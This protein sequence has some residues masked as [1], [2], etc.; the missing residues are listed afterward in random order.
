MLL[1]ILLIFLLTHSIVLCD[2]DDRDTEPIYSYQD[3]GTIVYREF[4]A[5]YS[6]RPFCPEGQQLT[7]M[8]MMSNCNA[9][10]VAL[11]TIPDCGKN[12]THQFFNYF[13]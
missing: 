5:N 7:N 12:F 6:V 8:L 11:Y 4:P 2:C 13:N 1:M 9:D 10:N 3:S